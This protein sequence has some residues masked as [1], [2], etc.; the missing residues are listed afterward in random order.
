MVTGKKA[1]EGKTQ[2][3]LIAAILEREP[4]PVT[5]LQ[6]LVPRTLDRVIRRGLSKDPDQRWQ[7][8]LD[9]AIQLQWVAETGPEAAVRRTSFG[10]RPRLWWSIGL[11]LLLLALAGWG[12]LLLQLGRGAAPL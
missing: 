10:G 2:A 4:T 5:S 8:A 11:G 3:S 6:P 7:S 9:L 12:G 1:F